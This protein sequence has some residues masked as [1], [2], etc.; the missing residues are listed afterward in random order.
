MTKSKVASFILIMMFCVSGCQ[1]KTEPTTSTTNANA[2]NATSP[3]KPVAPPTPEQ[4]SAAVSL[5]TPTDTYKA[6]YA[7]RQQKDL[8]LLKRVLSKEAQEFLADIGKDEKKTLDDQL[9]ELADKPQAKT[10]ETKNEKING[11]RATLEYLDEDG[12]WVTMDFVKEG[13]EWKI[14]LPKGP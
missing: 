6:G 3:A 7:A 5:A 14:D 2:Q 13:P 1:T 11:N 12:K 9:R 10:A 4:S 8:A